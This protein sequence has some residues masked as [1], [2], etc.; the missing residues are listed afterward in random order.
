M[1]ETLV[2]RRP[3]YRFEYRGQIRRRSTNL[4]DDLGPRVTSII[5]LL[6]RERQHLPELLEEEGGG[7]R[8]GVYA[9]GDALQKHRQPFLVLAVV[10]L[11]CRS[12]DLRVNYSLCRRL[13]LLGSRDLDGHGAG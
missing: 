13:R 3:Q 2:L 9:A 10:Q 8:L 11:D 1:R 4:Q 6:V 7:L 12:L 5:R